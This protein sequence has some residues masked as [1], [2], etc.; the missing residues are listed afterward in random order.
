MNGQLTLGENVADL[1]G[2]ILAYRA[3][4]TET[5]G[6]NPPAK[7]GLSPLQ[8]FFVGYAQS[9]CANTR[10]EAARMHAVTN[11]HSPE[12]YRTNGIVSNMPEFAAA[13]SCQAGQPMVR[14]PGCKVW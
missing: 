10:P 14:Q 1:G 2:V 9:W 5:A 12:K 11:A 3:W 6:K 13:F 4:M 8:R 7:D